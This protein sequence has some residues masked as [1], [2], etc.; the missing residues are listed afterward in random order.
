MGDRKQELERK[1]AK[2]AMIRA[3][4]TARMKEKESQEAASP[5]SSI[6]RRLE[7]LGIAPVKAVDEQIEVRHRSSS[8]YKEL[9]LLQAQELATDQQQHSEPDQEGPSGDLSKPSGVTNQKLALSRVT[10]PGLVSLPGE[11]GMIVR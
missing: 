11:S 1:K 5:T 2:L 9:P 3:Q 10:R 7:S 4:K 8:P 6:D